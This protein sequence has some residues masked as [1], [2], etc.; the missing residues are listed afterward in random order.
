MALPKLPDSCPWQ[1]EISKDWNQES[2]LVTLGNGDPRT[3]LGGK[4]VEIAPYASDD[5]IVQA[6][7]NAAWEIWNEMAREIFIR[8]LIE[9]HWPW[10]HNQS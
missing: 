5:A 6:V 2:I 7:E 9:R 3:Y 4:R 10:P 1:W 8:D